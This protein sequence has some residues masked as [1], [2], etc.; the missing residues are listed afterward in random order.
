MTDWIG[1]SPKVRMTRGR[2]R[3]RVRPPRYDNGALRCPADAALDDSGYYHEHPDDV[4][5]TTER[6][7]DWE[8]ANH[9]LV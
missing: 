8:I 5:V 9:S 6:S 3:L 1:V 4:A 2:G 7:E